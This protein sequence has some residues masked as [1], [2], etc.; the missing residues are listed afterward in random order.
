MH[1]RYIPSARTATGVSA[2]GCSHKQP[3]V[4]A[5]AARAPH[6]RSDRRSCCPLQNRGPTVPRLL[7]K[8]SH[9]LRAPRSAFVSYPLVRR[10]RTN[11]G[12]SFKINRLV[13]RVGRDEGGD[14]RDGTSQDESMHVVGTLVGVDGLEVHNVADNVVL[15]RNSVAAEHVAR[16]AGDLQRLATRIALD[17]RDHLGSVLLLL[18]KRAHPVAR[19]HAEGDLGRH[20]GHLFLGELVRCQRRAELLAV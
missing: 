4:H 18:H 9:R 15:V 19:L 7:L 20:V 12:K 1:S 13:G 5:H 2:R 10:R 16:V 11:V 3:N 17:H 14:V 8:S 6:R